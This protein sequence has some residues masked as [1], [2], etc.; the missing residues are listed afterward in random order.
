M[1][2]CLAAKAQINDL[3]L[4]KGVYLEEL[5]PFTLV[6]PHIPTNYRAYLKYKFSLSVKSLK[7]SL[8]PSDL[9]MVRA[10]RREFSRRNR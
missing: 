6:P 2:P 3:S 8:S 1:T 7:A 4:P 9:S 10:S 5:S